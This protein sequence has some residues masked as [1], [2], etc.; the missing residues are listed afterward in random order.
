MEIVIYSVMAIGAILFIGGM[1]IMPR[2]RRYMYKGSI[3]QLDDKN[4]R[5]KKRSNI[6][7]YI[8]LA[9]LLL[10]ILAGIIGG[11]VLHMW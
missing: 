11:N 6:G 10:L 1:G 7:L 5:Q 3:V 9:G 2:E 8:A 4:E